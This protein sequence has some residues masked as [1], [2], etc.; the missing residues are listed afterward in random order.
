[1]SVG[2]G[3]QVVNSLPLGTF[4]VTLTCDLGI[5]PPYRRLQNAMLAHMGRIRRF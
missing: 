4:R 2:L 5:L 1:M 3:Q